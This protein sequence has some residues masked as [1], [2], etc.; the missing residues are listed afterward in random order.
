MAAIPDE[1]FAATV[2]RVESAKNFLMTLEVKMRQ[3]HAM[4]AS[5]I[6]LV[7]DTADL[8][9]LLNDAR[10]VNMKKYGR[11]KAAEILQSIWSKLSPSQI[12]L[13]RSGK[14]GLG[15]KAAAECLFL[16]STAYVGEPKS[17]RG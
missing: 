16:N 2:E 5:K 14:Y 12:A 13:L 11:S 3:R 8:A 9:K 15:I 4:N 17:R 1:H 10:K 6:P 7:D